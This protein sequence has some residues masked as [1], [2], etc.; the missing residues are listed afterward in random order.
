MKFKLVEKINTLEVPIIDFLKS[1]FGTVQEPYL[2]P[3][4]ILP[5]GS[6]LNIS[7]CKHHSEV[8]KVLI[9]YGYSNNTY[10]A[11]GGSPTMRAI[12]AIRCDTVKYYIDLPNEQLSRAQ[13]NTLLI[14]LDY[15]SYQCRFVTIMANDGRI[16]TDYR[17]KETITDDIINRIRRYYI[18]GH[19]YEGLDESVKH[20]RQYDARFLRRPFGEE[21]NQFNEST[22]TEE[23]IKASKN[24]FI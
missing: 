19:L 10:I 21:L 22:I 20:T 14:W 4:Y 7:K 24:K 5:D 9:D 8:E 13:Y 23:K 15:L 11:T 17:F 3:T 16:S 2:G 6:M 12:G 1:Y 18:S